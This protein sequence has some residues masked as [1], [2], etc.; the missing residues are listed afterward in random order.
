MPLLAL[1]GCRRRA[2][3]S[4]PPEGSGP[5]PPRSWR[6]WSSRNRDTARASTCSAWRWSIF[7]RRASFSIFS[8]SMAWSG[9][10]RSFHR[11]LLG[12]PSRIMI[13]VLSGMPLAR[14]ASAVAS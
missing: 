9:T 11:S 4:P 14:M 10:L 7:I 1:G 12:R 8:R 3:S 5:C 13:I 6:G 2:T